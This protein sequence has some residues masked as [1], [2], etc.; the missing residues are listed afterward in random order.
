[1]K[2]VKSH[3]VQGCFEAI[4]A[5]VEGYVVRHDGWFYFKQGENIFYTRVTTKNVK[6][7]EVYL[8]SKDALITSP[9]FW[10][11]TSYEIYKIEESKWYDN[12][13]E[14]G[15]L[16]WVWN[17]PQDDKSVSL[18]RDYDSETPSFPFKSVG[19]LL[20]TNAQPLTKDEIQILLNNVPE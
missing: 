6:Q 10:K 13:P 11:F 14:P 18:I 3:E 1:M 4:A 9:G 5:I 15:I 16:C 17:S 8:V 19:H 12:I 20:W 7:K 2:F